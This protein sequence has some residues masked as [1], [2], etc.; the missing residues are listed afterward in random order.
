MD[1]EISAD[2]IRR[3]KLKTVIR[4]VVIVAAFVFI[5]IAFIAVI[6]IVL[7]LLKLPVGLELYALSLVLGGAAG[8]LLDRIR[9]GKVIDFIDVYVND[10]HWPA[11]N[12]AD[13]AL[14]VGIT[15]FIISNL[16]HKKKPS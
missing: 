10:W 15:L 13:A 1:R 4:Y 8:N 11:F 6:F 14:T 3:R 16:F 12:V 9:L 2:V 5:F 7:F